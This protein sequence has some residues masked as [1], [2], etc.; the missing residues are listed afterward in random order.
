M[1][2]KFS[3]FLF[4]IFLYLLASTPFSWADFNNNSP[5][6][7]PQP[8]QEM[9]QSNLVYPQEKNELQ[10]TL[11][12][13]FN[14]SNDSEITRT[15]FEIEYGITDAFQII[16]EWD[17]LL[18]KNMDDGP[19]YS[20]SGDIELG[21]QYSFMGLGDGDTH[22][23]LGSLAE[24]PIGSVESGLSDG[25]LEIQSFIVLAHDFPNY[26]QSQIFIEFGFNWIDQ[27]RNVSA[28]KARFNSFIWNIGAFF[29][30]YSW[31]ATIELNGKTNAWHGGNEN[32]IYITPG[33]I[34]K[35]SKAWE[36]GVATPIGITNS[37]DAYRA[38]GYLMWEFELDNVFD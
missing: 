37:S 24:I 33:F 2:L 34:Y 18:T 14:K 26:N 4:A 17:G 8:I 1:F 13:S 19:T 22:F 5:K 38:I 28:P 7:V 11:F 29:P 31:R 9:F 12:P 36:I 25:F 27:I 23:S 6:P 30:Y 15:L 21:V 32:N 35:L 16:F 3:Y 10:L 20:G